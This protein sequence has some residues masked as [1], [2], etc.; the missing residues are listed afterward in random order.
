MDN[1]D[2]ASNQSIIDGLCGLWV[3]LNCS[4]VCRDDLMLGKMA[5]QELSQ[6]ESEPVDAVG[7]LE[8]GYR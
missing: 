7:W 5:C 1:I 6:T 3:H 2:L 4:N 8:Y